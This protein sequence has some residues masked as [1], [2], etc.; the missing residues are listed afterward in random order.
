[1]TKRTWKSGPPPSI[2]WWNASRDR[3]EGSWRWWNGRYWSI[4]VHHG[5][6]ARTAG[7]RA[8]TESTAARQGQVLW[9]TYYPAN[10]RVARPAFARRR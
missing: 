8:S 4:P 5:K 1:M 3:N 6:S 2:G 9:T 10:A 7:E